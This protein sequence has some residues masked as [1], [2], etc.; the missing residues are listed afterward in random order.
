MVRGFE[1]SVIQNSTFE[2]RSYVS[3]FNKE[4]I[5]QFY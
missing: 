1:T 3:K 2:M 5:I 4:Y